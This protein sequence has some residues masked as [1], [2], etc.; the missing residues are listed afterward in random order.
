MVGRRAQP[1]SIEYSTIVPVPSVTVPPLITA[2]D[3]RRSSA[4]CP[5]PVVLD[6]RW[7]LAGSDE[8]G[9]D[10]AGQPGSSVAGLSAPGPAVLDGDLASSADY[11]V[12]HVPGARFLDLDR[13]LAAAPGLGGRHPLPEPGDLQA[14]LRR[15]GLSDDDEVVV[16]DGGPALAAARAWWL[17]RW[18]GL[19]R[20]R[21]LD[22]GFPAWTTD[23]ARPTESGPAGAVAPGTITVRPG[24]L[25]VVDVDGAAAAVDAPDARLLDVRAAA[26]YRGEVEPL[27]PVAGHIPGALNL[28]IADL[29]RADGTYRSAGELAAVLAAAGVTAGTRVVASCGS[30]V[31]AC[32]LVLAGE[33]VGI[34]VT[35]YPGSYSQ[36]CALGRPVATGG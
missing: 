33:L 17:L 36:W 19:T 7:S 35:L 20:V 24:G 10:R 3:L 30:G 14:A 21:V 15:V 23:P 11:L 5:P 6:I 27:D 2:E 16:Y 8:P 34:P 22:G 32:Q 25:P 28:P 31:T 9:Y 1:V 12:A 29:M 18:S 13:E 26:R 4:A